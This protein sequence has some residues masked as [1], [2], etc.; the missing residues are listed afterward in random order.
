MSDI[1]PPNPDDS[2]RTQ[3]WVKRWEREKQPWD[4]GHV[5]PN[6]VSFLTQTGIAPARVLIPGCG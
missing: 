6:L 2:F 5:P 4:L 1:L 3:F